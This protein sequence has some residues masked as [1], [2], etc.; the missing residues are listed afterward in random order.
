[1]STYHYLQKE[2]SNMDEKE[3]AQL[4]DDYEDVDK[5]A[6]AKVQLM[7]AYNS[8]FN[9]TKDLQK[10]VDVLRE[11]NA[12]LALRVTGLPAKEEPEV[13]PAVQFE[14]EMDTK[15]KDFVEGI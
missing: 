1:M 12:K 9:T 13:D 6:F 15:I 5:R 11:Q 8:A 7:E 10:S 2:V 3:F 4:L 14:K